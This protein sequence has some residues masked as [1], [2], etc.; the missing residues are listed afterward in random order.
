MWLYRNPHNPAIFAQKSKNYMRYGNYM[1][2][3]FKLDEDKIITVVYGCK[4]KLIHRGNRA[5]TVFLDAPMHPYKRSVRRSVGRLISWL[6]GQ[7]ISWLV[8]QSVRFHQIATDACLLEFHHG[9]KQK[10][11]YN[12]KTVNR[13]KIKLPPLHSSDNFAQDSGFTKFRFEG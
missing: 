11:R 13:M 7:S 5:K 3:S 8:S 9:N 12:T 2:R 10:I 6:V 4:K 1:K